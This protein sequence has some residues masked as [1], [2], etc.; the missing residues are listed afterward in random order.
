MINC[1]CEIDEITKKYNSEWINVGKVTKFGHPHHP[2]YLKEREK[3]NTFDINEYIKKASIE[4]V[5]SYI[6]IFKNKYKYNFEDFYYTLEKADFI[7]F[8]YS[9]QLKTKPI[10]INYELKLLKGSDFDFVKALLTGIIRENYFCNGS[11]DERVENGD[12][13]RVLKK[14]RYCYKLP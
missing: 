8:N 9:N 3:Y 14:L 5:Y 4:V 12:V 6:N 2:L 7:D 1:L 13:I 11:F 10:D